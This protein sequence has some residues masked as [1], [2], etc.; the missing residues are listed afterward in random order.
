M[1][2][3]GQRDPKWANIKLG[4]SNVT[5]GGY[6]CTISVIGNIV[7]ATPDVVNQKLKGVDG[8]ANQNLVIWGKISQ[9]F[10][11]FVVTR[12]FGYNNADVLSKV[13][14]VICEVSAAAIGSPRTSHW[15]QYL[16]GGKCADP[17]TGRIRPTTDF[18]IPT[19]YAII[20]PKNPTPNPDPVPNPEPIGGNMNLWDK[21]DREAWR[22]AIAVSFDKAPNL[23]AEKEINDAIASNYP[24]PASWILADQRLRVYEPQIDASYK[25][26]LKDCQGSPEELDRLRRELGESTLKINNALKALKP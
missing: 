4:T 21:N 2:N 23:V 17:W 1:L 16:G 24:T 11:D 3:N 5:I 22:V 25:K 26:G 6:G 14:Y 15:I 18:G 13:P 19:G 7:G 8:F 12:K 10:P 20:Y 9:A